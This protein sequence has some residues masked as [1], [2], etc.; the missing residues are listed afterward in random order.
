MI[1]IFTF[2]AG[3]EVHPSANNSS[4]KTLK[5][6]S[7]AAKSIAVRP[8]KLGFSTKYF[9]TRLAYVDYLITPTTFYTSSTLA[10][11]AK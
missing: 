7:E 4:A 6:Q 3:V 5:G 2:V 1:R 11:T 8:P 9:S 10:E